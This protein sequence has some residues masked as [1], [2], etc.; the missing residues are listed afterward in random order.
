MPGVLTEDPGSSR[1]GA[2]PRVV[3]LTAAVDP[4]VV[5]PAGIEPQPEGSDALTKAAVPLVVGS[6]QPGIEQPAAV[7]RT[8]CPD[9]RR[10]NVGPSPLT[11]LPGAVAA[12]P[13]G[14]PRRASAVRVDGPT[15][16]VDLSAGT[17]ALPQATVVKA[18]DPTQTARTAVHALS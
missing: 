7:A 14:A 15:R 11:V 17:G 10:G 8:A 18:G 1:I 16:I 3:V 12:P 5:V 2:P 9:R 13:I 6:V 4:A